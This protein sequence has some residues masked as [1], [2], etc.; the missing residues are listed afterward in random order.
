M[1]AVR[2]RAADLL[3][4]DPLAIGGLEFSHLGSRQVGEERTTQIGSAGPTM[5]A[6]SEA[7][8]LTHPSR[9]TLKRQIAFR[10]LTVY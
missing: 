9:G 6:P 7:K 10:P 4:V 1:L 8:S 2:P 3:M 5:P